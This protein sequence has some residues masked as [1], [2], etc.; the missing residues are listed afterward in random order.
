MARNK[1][2]KAKQHLLRIDIFMRL[3]GNDDPCISNPLTPK[4]MLHFLSSFGLR[5]EGA[6]A[7]PSF[8]LQHAP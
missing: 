3:L 1:T 6:A 2:G 7:L 5:L 8:P 4:A